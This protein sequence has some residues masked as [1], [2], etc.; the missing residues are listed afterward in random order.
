VRSSHITQIATSVVSAVLIRTPTWYYFSTAM[1]I[2][3]KGGMAN[4]APD[5]LIRGL[6]DIIVANTANG[7]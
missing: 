6:A 5:D 1:S 2:I 3:T 4:P 7:R